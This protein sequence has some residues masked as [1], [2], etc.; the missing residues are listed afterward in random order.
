MIIIIILNF[1]S[2]VM[3]MVLFVAASYRFFASYENMLET[4]WGYRVDPII[5]AAVFI[6][7]SAH[8]RQFFCVK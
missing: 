6:C 5:I 3:M 2:G 8:L 4:V 1:Y 7:F